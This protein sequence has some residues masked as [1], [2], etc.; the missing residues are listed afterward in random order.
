M[1]GRKKKLWTKEEKE[2]LLKNYKQMGSKYCADQLG[3]TRKAITTQARNWDVSNKR[4]EFIRV[5]ECAEVQRRVKEGKCQNCADP[6]GYPYCCDRCYKN[7]GMI[8]NWFEY[9]ETQN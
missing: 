9:Y 4:K 6:E 2:F 3:R 5:A 1:K 7:L 8:E